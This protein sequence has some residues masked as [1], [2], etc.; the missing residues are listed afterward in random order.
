MLGL[1][2]DS[3]VRVSADVFEDSLKRYGFGELE[4]MASQKGHF[5]RVYSNIRTKI[6]IAS[7]TGNPNGSFTYRIMRKHIRK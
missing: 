4:T 5:S 7:I 3:M 2:K 1:F 6:V